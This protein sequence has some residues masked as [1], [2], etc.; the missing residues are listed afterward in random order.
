MR[1]AIVAALCCSVIGLAVADQAKAAITKPTDIPAQ[2]L[3]PALKEL[4]RDRGFQVVFRSEVVGDA[5]TQGAHGE[6]TTADALT[7]LL[8]GTRLAYKYLDS[9]TVTILTRAEVQSDAT[10]SADTRNTREGDL[11]G[12]HAEEQKRNRPFRLAQL[13]QATSGSQ[14]A[15]ASE[16]K[17]TAGLEE[18]IVTAQKRGDERLQDVPVP[19]TVLS[20]TALTDNN[21]VRLQDYFSQVPGLSVSPQIAE[22]IQTITIRGIGTGYG[23]NPTVGLT[24]DDVPIGTSAIQTP[25]PDFDPSDLERV[26]VLRG[27]Q[28]TLYGASSMGG[29]IKYVTKDP[30]PDG[31]SGRV[32]AGV[33]GVHNGAEPGYDFR[34]SANIP[35]GDTA[36]IRISGFT[37]QD[38]GY[39]DNVLTG[40][41]GVNKST[42][43]GGRLAALWRPSDDFSVKLSAL[44]QYFKT[45]GSDLVVFPTT[46]Y[47]DSFGLKDLQQN[48]IPN[49]G[50]SDRTYQAYSATLNYKLSGV[51]LTSVSGYNI[52]KY[53]GSLD[54]TY[55]LGGAVAAVFPDSGAAGAPFVD[56]E[57]AT[58]FVQ[59]IRLSGSIWRNVDWL[60]GGF[61][62]HERWTDSASIPAEIISTGQIVGVVGYL[63]P[64]NTYQEYAGFANLT[65]HFTDRFDV[66]IGGRESSLTVTHAEVD[67]GP[68]YGPTPA[69]TAEEKSKANAFTYLVTPRFKLSSDLM[70]YARLASGYR[71]GGPNENS[72]AF[73]GQTPTPQSFSP[74]KTKNYELGLKGDFFEN[75]LSVDASVYYIDWTA[76]QVGITATSDSFGYTTNGGN[77]KSDGV[78]LSFTAKP[79]S[80]LTVAAWFD[81]D[82]AVLTKAFPSNATI[83]G[84]PG[85][86]LP[87]SSRFSG[88]ASVEQEFP[89]SHNLTGYVGAQSNFVGDSLGQFTSPPPTIPPRQRYPSYTKTDLRAGLKWTDWTA[90]LYVNN[91]TDKRGQLSGGLGGVPP[92]S[93]TLLQPRTVGLNVV[94]SF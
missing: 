14:V 65:Y 33:S 66:Q 64:D 84:V 49:T 23:T 90:N 57:R 29:L 79:L 36:A 18:I 42:A 43:E 39:I 80:G 2:G 73:A 21:Q 85:D 6:L 94:R 63:D 7:Q 89:V 31:Y 10:G 61:Y 26:E 34:A 71:P 72:I 52:V 5:R 93:Y 47:P 81:Y 35:V 38:P 16:G 77:A 28:G 75:T 56:N 91:V 4:A 13:D 67:S 8:Q 32:E 69:I 51:D 48:F 24:L 19:V 17:P 30:S 60:V 44:Y 88:N 37:R 87:Y 1:L 59:E 46:G 40:Q 25:P 83:S 78:E 58:K 22:G 9:N 68:L 3:G 54:Y 27:P 12:D 76:I 11:S 92:F 55:G 74:D 62:T 20:A 86:R 41:D 53:N 82:D 50:G 15:N 70:V 45:D